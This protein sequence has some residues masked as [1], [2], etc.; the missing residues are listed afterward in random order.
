[1][2]PI[3]CDICSTVARDNMYEGF[4]LCCIN[5]KNRQ[6]CKNCIKD[7]AIKNIKFCIAAHKEYLKDEKYDNN[8]IERIKDLEICV[9]K[10]EKGDLNMLNGFNRI[11]NDKTSNI[12]ECYEDIPFTSYHDKCI[13]IK[14]RWS[15]QIGKY[16]LYARS[17]DFHPEILDPV[18][19]LYISREGDPGFPKTIKI[20]FAQRE[21]G[22]REYPYVWMNKDG[23]KRIIDKDEYWK[24]VMKI[25]H[26]LAMRDIREIGF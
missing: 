23:I 24:R 13:R 4:D 25:G 7:V 26:I 1:M 22:I 8:L 9:D 18:K 3:K 20:Q 5:P 11:D 10:L 14:S 19:I 17:P 6:F 12:E 15:D 16:A 2:N 21:H